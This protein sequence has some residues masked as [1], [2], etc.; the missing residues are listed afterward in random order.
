MTDEHGIPS[1]GNFSPREDGADSDD[2]LNESRWE[3]PNLDGIDFGARAQ[4]DIENTQSLTELSEST[5]TALHAIQA[6]EAQ[7]AEAAL[8]APEDPQPAEETQSFDPLAE[9]A[10]EAESE[11]EP[12]FP[13]HP[14]T[15]LA[16]RESPEPELEP[17]ERET[18]PVSA[19]DELDD[20]AEYEQTNATGSFPPLTDA[21]PTEV[22]TDT[23]A[24]S[25]RASR[26]SHRSPKSEEAKQQNSTNRFLIIGV[27]SVIVLAL[28][29]GFT[30]FF[31]NTA[32]AATHEQLL[33]T[34]TQSR[35]AATQSSAS[36][37]TTISDAQSVADTQSADVEDTAVLT[38]AK[39]A[40]D[41]AKASIENEKNLDSCA[42]EMTDNQL[43]SLA[44][45]ADKIVANQKTYT[46]TISQTKSAVEK[47][48]QSKTQAT[49][50]NSLTAKRQEAQ[51]LYEQSKGKVTDET[52][53]ENLK[54]AIDA[55]DE[56]I[57]Q[58]T[59]KVTA[60][61]YSAAVETLTNTITAVQNSMKTYEEQEAKKKAEEERKNVAGICSAY[62]GTYSSG[63]TQFTL[64]GDCSLQ[65]GDN[66]T[67]T[68]TTCT[69]ADGSSGACATV[70]NEDNPSR[71]NWSIA[72]SAGSEG[73][74]TGTRE[75]QNANVTLSRN[76]AGASINV[77]GQSFTRQ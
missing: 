11:P 77:G 68:P 73:A 61:Q 45:N 35:Q 57:A 5:S 2:V 29:I 18:E 52:T 9:F 65:Y 17:A 34:C 22:E 40:I 33:N 10:S 55:A 3:I 13:V 59:K 8:H 58:S 67:G 25:L 31:R 16:E 44:D 54:K 63:A 38:K 12:A 36:L 26:S 15:P 1:M 69:F 24:A 20:F 50:K 47:S 32:S 19:L 53:R 71:I 14:A 75:C 72:C 41:Q 39:N 64:R 42:T 66:S 70:D 21:L 60:D 30:I 6:Q 46:T 4:Q 49:A 76:G 43:R 27:V 37:N 74:A 62:A 48:K 28:I 7:D 23:A 56:L 51:S